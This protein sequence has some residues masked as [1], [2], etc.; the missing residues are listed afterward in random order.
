M[1]ENPRGAMF[2]LLVPNQH[3][4]VTYAE[5]FFDLVFVFAVTQLSH[6][7]LG[8]FT[9]LG[10]VQNTMLFLAV[11]WAWVYTTWITNW[12][13]PERLAVRLLVL[14]L[15]FAGLLLSTALPEAFDGRAKV[16]ALAY[17]FMQVGRSLFMVWAL[18]RAPQAARFNF[19]RI[20]TWLVV[21]GVLWMIG[22][23]VAAEARLIWWAVALGIEYCGPAMFF[24]VPGLGRSSTREWDVEGGHMAERCAC[25]IIIALGESIV[26]TGAT[27]A[28]TAWTTTA[29]TA[30]IVAQVGAIA[31]WWVYFHLGAEAGSERIS[32]SEET[33]RLARLAYTYMH[34]PIVAGIVVAAVGDELLLAHPEGHSGVKAIIGMVGG[35]LLFLIGTLL[36]KRIIR[37]IFQLSHLAGI[38]LLLLLI[39]LAHNLSPLLLSTATTVIMLG[40]AIWEARSLGS[41][42]TEAKSPRR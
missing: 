24:Y 1:T 5:L 2:R 16:F 33:G 36:F 28:E 25:F 29:I 10:V 21:T 27:F 37:G 14:A 39:P 42:Q 23:F 8:N 17:V 40:V 12:L 13:D 22:A 19:Y 30:F 11:W 31:M 4:R 41:H 26:V 7:L 3:S 20:T 35:P 6:T 9:P 15:M 38:A 18:R 34:I 32:Q